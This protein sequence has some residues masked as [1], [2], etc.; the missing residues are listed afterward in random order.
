MMCR[1]DTPKI[2]KTCTQHLNEAQG[3]VTEPIEQ[4]INS[5]V[6]SEP[7]DELVEQEEEASLS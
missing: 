1:S 2:Q 4:E 3:N 7:L 5:S 6:E